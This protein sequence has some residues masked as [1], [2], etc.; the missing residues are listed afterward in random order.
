MALLYEADY[1]HISDLGDKQ[2][3]FREWTTKEER[4]YLNTIEKRKD[5]FTDKTIYDILISPCIEDKDIVLS[6]AQQKKLLIDIRIK[7]ISKYVESEHECKSCKEKNNIKEEIENFMK[8]IPSKF[9]TVEIEDI[10]F[11]FGDIKS[12]KEKNALKLSDGIINYVFKDFLLHI[13]KIEMNEE[14]HENLSLKDKEKFIDSLPSR[15]FDDV[16]D[17]YKEMV[18]DLELNYDFSCSECG[19]KETID[20]TNIPNLLWA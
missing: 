1:K 9:K 8:Y 3:K 14:T 5:D 7:S 17:E 11:H 13:D 6:S 12:N 2:V 19:T 10:K 15:I 18:D 20:Y 16:F 4:K